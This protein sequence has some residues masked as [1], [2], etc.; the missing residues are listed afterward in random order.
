MN[1]ETD[2]LIDELRE[3][4][5]ASRPSFSVGLHGRLMREINAERTASQPSTAPI[6][7]WSIRGVAPQIAIASAAVLAATVCI[8]VWRPVHPAPSAQPGP[9]VK[10][11][12]PIKTREPASVTPTQ[13]ATS[14]RPITIDLDEIASLKLLPV[15]LTLRVPITI[16]PRHKKS[17]HQ[18]PTDV[19]AQLAEAV[20]QPGR[21]IDNLLFDILPLPRK[22][23]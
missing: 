7:R 13:L 3:E 12:P 11:V 8:V 2:L 18:R 15:S 5:R 1:D 6:S 21:E 23:N 9:I 19:S 20:E 10:V 17:R 4:G 14:E 22:K 16:E